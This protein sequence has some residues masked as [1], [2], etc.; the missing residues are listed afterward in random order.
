MVR[1]VKHRIIVVRTDGVPVN[2]HYEPVKTISAAARFNDMEGY[3]TF[4]TGHF[5]PPDRSIY[6][7]KRLRITY[8]LEDDGDDVTL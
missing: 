6:E 4:M 1:E 5:K 2:L 8:E 7:P 3:E